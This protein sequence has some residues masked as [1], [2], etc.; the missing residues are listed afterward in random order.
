MGMAQSQACEKEL[1]CDGVPSLWLEVGEGG[2]LHA[3]C[4]SLTAVKDL[5]WLLVLWKPLPVLI[6]SDRQLCCPHFGDGDG[7]GFGFACAPS[8]PSCHCCCPFVCHCGAIY[9]CCPFACRCDAICCCVMK[10]VPR[11]YDS[12]SH[13]VCWGCGIAHV[14]CVCYPSYRDWVTDHC[15]SAHGLVGMQSAASVSVCANYGERSWSHK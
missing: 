15:V 10:A 8:C 9:C 13:G 6:F 3:L 7:Q 14:C 1:W 12:C 4:F 11:Q 2:W 5:A